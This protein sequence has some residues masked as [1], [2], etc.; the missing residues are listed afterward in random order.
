MH[1]HSYLMTSAYQPNG[2]RWMAAFTNK[3]IDITQE[4]QQWCY[5]A[6]GPP[7]FKVNTDEI[8]WTDGA[9][10]G[11]IIFGREEDLMLFM[12]KWQT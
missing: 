2:P 11:E 5:N 7:G 12:L 10:R 4:I 9:V 8:R 1:I 3:N 6:F